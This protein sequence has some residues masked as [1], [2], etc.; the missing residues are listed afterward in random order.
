MKLAFTMVSFSSSSTEGDGVAMALSVMELS[1]SL[2]QFISVNQGAWAN[3]G[4]MDSHIYRAQ[5][6]ER[7]E[8][9]KLTPSAKLMI[10][11][12]TA[13]IKNKN[14]ILKAMETLPEP[15]KQEAWF[16]PVKDFINVETE[17]YVTKA[18]KTKRFPLVNIPNTNPGLDILFGMM[19]LKPEERTVEKMKDRVTFCQLNLAADM[20]TLAK[21]G[22]ENFW[23]NVVK[24]TK[25]DDK[26]EEPKMREEYYKNPESDKYNL[27]GLDMKQVLPR[28]QSS[29]YTRM[30]LEEYLRSVQEDMDKLLKEDKKEEKKETEQEKK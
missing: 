1:K 28:S 13:V 10:Y 30:E 16:Y 27:V 12:F 23:N 11:F 4:K 15:V 18:E 19:I 24:G 25:N 2:V 6:M 20:Q 17:Q 8:M 14:R 22:Y 7:M 29:G 3:F 5:L 26:P 9:K 21:A